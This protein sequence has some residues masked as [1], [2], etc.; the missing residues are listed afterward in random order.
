[1]A[2]DFDLFVIGGGS[3]GV[4]AAR[5]A[6]GLGARVALAEEYRMGGTCVIRG[7][8]PKK[9]LVYA[10]HFAEEM[11]EAASLGWDLGEAKF[12]W[13]KLIANKDREITRLEGLY[14]KTLANAG[15]EVF[16]RR[17]VLKDAHT[18]ALA[19]GDNEARRVTAETI[20][21]ATGGWPNLPDIPGVAHAITSNEALSL[22][23]LPG[24][25][26]IAGAGYI[27]VEFAGIF[28][29]LGA[30]T[31]VVYR[32]D[33]VLRGFDEDLRRRLTGE[34]M[35]RGVDFI[36]GTNITSIE[37]TADGLVVAFD[38]EDEEDQVFD[39][40]MFAIGRQPNTAGLGLEEVGVALNGKG[41]IVVDEYSRSNIAN[42]YAVGDVTDR[43]ALTPV[44]IKEGH[45]FALTVYGDTPVSPCHDNVP[46]AVFSQPPIGTVGLSE[47]DAREKY[48]AIEV[49]KSSF[50]PLKYTLGDNMGQALIKMIVDKATDKVVGAHMLGADAPEIIQ[51][52]AIAVR[53]GLTK[54]QF[55][56]TVAIHPSSAEEFVLMRDPVP[57]TGG[58]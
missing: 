15:V 47:E 50:R 35:N 37:K 3:G 28:N 31:T 39:A 33:K 25:I 5:I 6:G 51:G 26:L 42:I 32:R 45:A 41:A 34:M 8:I 53:N 19:A 44:A 9:L 21:I 16:E 52:V 48:G 22:P 17:A 13:A 12:D 46:A 30:E 58:D 54:A 4:R 11:E 43:I 2:Y 18:L 1:M 40:V 29:G 24:R 38:N 23:E 57:E 49:Y 20:L 36:F 10:S 55:D 14:G 27:A 56:Q 7:C